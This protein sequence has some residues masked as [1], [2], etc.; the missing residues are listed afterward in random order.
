MQNRNIDVMQ[1]T[2]LV[3]LSHAIVLLRLAVVLSRL[4]IAPLIFSLIGDTNYLSPI[5]IF[6]FSFLVS[7]FSLRYSLLTHSLTQKETNA[8]GS[9]LSLLL[10][11]RR[12]PTIEEQI[13]HWAAPK[14]LSQMR[15]LCLMRCPI[16]AFALGVF[17]W[18]KRR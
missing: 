12:K 4:A 6:Y 17:S 5:H 16:Q 13:L 10:L 1:H 9:P 11:L 8:K 2:T 14:D 18:W 7:A 3:F 15:P